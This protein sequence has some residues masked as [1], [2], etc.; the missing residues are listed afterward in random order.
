MNMPVG[1]IG[2]LTLAS[3]AV[4]DTNEDMFFEAM[5]DPCVLVQG[6]NVIAVEIHQSSP[7]SSDIG[8]DLMLTPILGERVCSADVSGDDGVVGVPD[9]LT[10]IN[11]WGPCAPPPTDCPADLSPSCGDNAVGVPDLLEVINGWG[12]CV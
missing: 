1:T 6:T 7:S 9:L 2:Y 4:G 3:F 10:V 12:P 5:L 11:S 8:L